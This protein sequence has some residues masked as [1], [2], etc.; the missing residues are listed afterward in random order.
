MVV[1]FNE[2]FHKFRI[3]TPTNHAGVLIA[4]T[5]IGRLSKVDQ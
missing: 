4:K 2:A 5:Q 1:D 3:F